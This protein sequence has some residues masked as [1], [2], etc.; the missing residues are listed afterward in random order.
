MTNLLYG[1]V[2]K[3]ILEIFL[4]ASRSF[5]SVRIAHLRP[6]DAARIAQAAVDP[7]ANAFWRSLVWSRIGFTAHYP[8]QPQ[9]QQLVRQSWQCAAAISSSR[10]DT[11]Q[12]AAWHA[13][14]LI[15]D[16]S[17]YGLSKVIDAMPAELKREES[18]LIGADEH[19]PLAALR[20]MRKRPSLR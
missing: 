19:S 8:A 5:A 12:L 15:R 4:H 16:G 14:A 18:G 10:S 6:A 17:W 13:R 2:V 3:K 7:K 1:C 9:G 20:P 11:Q